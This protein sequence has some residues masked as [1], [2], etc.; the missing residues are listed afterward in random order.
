MPDPR[1]IHLRL[2]S[3]YSV[4]DGIVRVDSA[5]ARAAEFGMPALGLSDLANLFALVKFY[6]S[7]RGKGIKP[8]VGCDIYLAN[9]ADP[10]RPYRML[11]LC[12]SRQGYLQLCRL[13]TAAYLRPRIRGRAEIDREM[14]REIGV[15]GLIALSGAAS[16]DIGEALSQGNQPLAASRADPAAA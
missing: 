7:A 8:I 1:F 5:V 6:L 11:L 12:R 3:E 14:L 13:L 15:D 9:E 2:H 10:D 4:T 16:G